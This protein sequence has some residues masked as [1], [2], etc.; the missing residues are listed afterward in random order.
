MDVITKFVYE[1]PD[2]EITVSSELFNSGIKIVM[3]TWENRIP[4]ITYYILNPH[5]EFPLNE[6]LEALYADILRFKEKSNA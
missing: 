6:L 5:E 2:I 1:H 3:K 4:F